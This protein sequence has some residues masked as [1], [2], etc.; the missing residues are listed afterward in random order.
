MGFF[1]P[2]EYKSKKTGTVYYL[3]FKDVNKNRLY[4]FSK[5]KTDAINDLPRGFDVVEN[6]VQGV[7]FLKK[8][9]GPAGKKPAGKEA[10]ASTGEKK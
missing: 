6:Q 4:Y 8:I 7:P 1:G 10:V 5:D 3:H 2:Y 9:G